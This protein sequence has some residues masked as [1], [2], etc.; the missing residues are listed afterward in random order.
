MVREAD[1]LK[2]V[3]NLL[4]KF[5]KLVSEVRKASLGNLSQLHCCELLAMLRNFFFDQYCMVEPLSLAVW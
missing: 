4:T 3:V 1:W 5:M 2:L